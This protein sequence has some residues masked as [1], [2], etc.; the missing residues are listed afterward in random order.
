MDRATRKTVRDRAGSCCEYCR[1]PL[2]VVFEVEHIEAL[3]HIV[4]DS[5]D[6]LALSWNAIVTKGQT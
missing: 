1:R 3:Q 2:N 5:L 4:D 6:N